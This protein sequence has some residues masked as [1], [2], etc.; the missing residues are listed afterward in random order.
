MTSIV[1]YHICINHKTRLITRGFK[2][3]WMKNQWS[4]KK[5]QSCNQKNYLPYIT[6]RN[7]L[8]CVTL[9][10][11][12]I[13]SLTLRKKFFPNILLGVTLFDFLINCFECSRSFFAHNNNSSNRLFSSKKFRTLL[14]RC[15][16]IALLVIEFYYLNNFLLGRWIRLETKN[17]ATFIHF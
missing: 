13:F 7:F 9:T 10:N 6:L 5:I 17:K 12:V 3:T 11:F 8:F 2:S 16:P 14:T 1:K 4:N 15:L